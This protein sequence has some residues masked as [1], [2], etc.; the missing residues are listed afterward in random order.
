MTVSAGAEAR[1]PKA[2]HGPS[3][4]AMGR[5]LSARIIGIL[6]LFFA[7]ALT[8]VGLTLYCARQLEGVAAAINDAGSLRMRSW[9]IAHQL[10]GL[11]PDGAARQRRLATIAAEISG[12]EAVQAA[13]VHGDPER[14]LFIP[15]DP[16]IAEAVEQ[17]GAEWRQR[18]RPLADRA[19]AAG[20]PDARASSVADFE[21]AT[22]GYVDQIDSVVH[23]M[24]LRYARSTNLLR[25][26]QLVLLV[27]ALVGGVVLVRFFVVVVIRPVRSL[28]AGMQR[29]ERR[30]LAARVPVLT[31][32]ELG[33][34]A[35]G[36]NRMAEQLED[37]YATLEER[38]ESK[39]RSLARRNRELR[40]L[41]EISRTLRDPVG[42]EEL[43][44]RF[45]E[46][47]RATFCASAATVR[48]FDPGG[49]RL[50]LISHSG[51]AEDFLQRESGLHCTDCLCGQAARFD[52]PVVS[53]T[54]RIADGPL[55]SACSKA[56]FVTISAIPVNHMGR[57]LGVFNLFFAV[58]TAFSSDDLELLQTLGQQLGMAIENARLKMR[59]QEMAV[60]E[61]RNLIARQ[62][63]DSIAQGL[64]YL[65]LQV[66]ILERALTEGKTSEALESAAL[67]H[68]GV[69][70]GYADVRELLQHFRARFDQ[71]DLSAALRVALEKFT[72]HSGVPGE[73]RAH[74]VGAPFNAEIEM[75]VIYIV[76]E[77]LSNIRKHARAERV[78][79]DLWREREELRLTVGDD[80][81]G[82]EVDAPGNGGCGEHIGLQIMDERARRIGGTLEIRSRP[83]DGTRISFRVDRQE[84]EQDKAP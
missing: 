1:K 32:D 9:K 41:Y 23:Q 25:G 40:I 53:T 78:R 52:V 10:T 37:V 5:K 49:S 34:L 35:H 39:T 50:H 64:A 15:R 17:L 75:Q 13:L 81:V 73:F 18:I 79:V 68:R 80:G 72:E 58:R 46:R 29:M 62:L 27:L 43:S 67:I 21:Q 28:Q 22:A 6:L 33:A 38:V 70:E 65:N 36:F 31:H 84:G 7:A 11:P 45:L 83:G 4:D 26:L 54:E 59:E 3:D 76:Q 63:H 44:G 2:I 30:D 74:G 47:I 24:E 82:F 48:L 51:L 14:P 56:G 42:V 60:S 71:Q 55:A 12:L 19:I 16:E 77:A 66:Q 8:S 69:Q 20:N 57:S 61:E